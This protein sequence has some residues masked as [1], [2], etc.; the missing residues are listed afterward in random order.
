M[1]EQKSSHKLK[2]AITHGDINGISYEVIIKALSDNRIF[3]FCTPIIYGS[4]KVLAYHRK[5]LRVGTFNVNNIRNTS[6]ANPKRV[7]ILNC[8]SDNVRV[9]LGKSTEIAG[10]SSLAA[11]EHAIND[12]KNGKVDVLVT[13]PIN[14]KNIQSEKF[15]FAGHTE[16]L[17]TEFEAEDSLMFLVSEKLKVGVVTGHVPIV[18]V[19][20][21]LT[22]EL[23]MS[24]IRLMHNSLVQDF[25]INKPR[26]AVLGLNPHAGDNGLIG[27]EELETIIPALEQARKENILAIGPFSPDGIFGSSQYAEFDAILAMYHDQG[28]SPFKALAFEY[29]VN[30]TAGLSVVRTSPDHGTAYEIAGK[31][32]ASEVSL[33]EAIYLACEVYN[34]RLDYAELTQNPLPTND[35][36]SL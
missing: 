36:T 3:D 31:R 5:A 1:T 4:P 29:G 27:Q 22:Q 13:A 28:L 15:H 25:G 7:N 20:K 6:E 21:L 24:K 10:E 12:L 26:I 32:Q 33:R 11:L 34:K 9:E 2:V 17:Q 35:K 14:K 8:V 18:D 30:F 23:I 16:Y 19:P